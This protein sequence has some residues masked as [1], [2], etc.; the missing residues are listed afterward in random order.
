MPNTLCNGWLQWVD[1][2][3]TRLPNHTTLTKSHQFSL[4]AQPQVSCNSLRNLISLS[5]HSRVTQNYLEIKLDAAKEVAICRLLY[6]QSMHAVGLGS[7]CWAIG[8]SCISEWLVTWLVP[9]VPMP[10]VVQRVSAR[11][12]FLLETPAILPYRGY[13]LQFALQQHTELTTCTRCSLP[14]EICLYF[15]LFKLVCIP[16]FDTFSHN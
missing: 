9:Q 13:D 3:L 7:S 15:D 16:F 10:L 8:S 1:G 2:C 6:P 14:Q 4:H 5:I 12:L 11:S